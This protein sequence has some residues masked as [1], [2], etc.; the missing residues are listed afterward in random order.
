M[1]SSHPIYRA[2]VTYSSSSTGEIRVKIPALLGADSE[3]AISYIGRKSPWVVPTV[4]DQIVVTSDDANL[5]NI[6][7]LQTDQSSSTVSTSDASKANIDSPT[8]TG[9]VTLPSTTSIGAVSSTEIGY[10]DGVTSAIQTQLNN[11]A[12]IASPSFSGQVSI[13]NAFTYSGDNSAGGLTAYDYTPVKPPTTYIN[14]GSCFNLSTGRFTLPVAG[15][16]LCSFNSLINRPNTTSH[17]YVHFEV[18]GV[19]KAARTHTA[20]DV[21]GTYETLS[22]TAIVYCPANSYITCIFGTYF[23]ATTFDGEWGLGLTYRFLG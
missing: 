2:L 5:T 18:D 19:R 23:G 3:V 9:T 20:V 14:N 8:F 10:V 16:V 6:F 12:P 15:Y 4:G 13:P 11:K 7:W 22:N 1:H 17:A 21:A